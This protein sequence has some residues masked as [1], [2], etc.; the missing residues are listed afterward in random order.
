MDLELR[1]V[2]YFES[3]SGRVDAL[4]SNP[5]VHMFTQDI[6]LAIVPFREEEYEAKIV[7]PEEHVR[8]ATKLL[9]SI[10]RHGSR[11][12]REIV[13]SAVRAIAQNMTWY[14]SA[15]YEIW[16]LEGTTGLSSFT[17]QFR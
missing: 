9:E 13:G 12:I 16:T 15:C 11:G 3:L 2:P 10:E 4:V 1:A 8:R 5:L 17:P 7:G 6:P 14:G